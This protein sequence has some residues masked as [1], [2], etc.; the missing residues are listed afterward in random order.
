MYK[1]IVASDLH[2]DSHPKRTP[3]RDFRL[4]QSFIV[5]DNII[6]LAK[7]EGATNFLFL[8]GDIVDKHDHDSTTHHVV[9]ECLQRLADSFD[10]VYFILGNH[11]ILNRSVSAESREGDLKFSYI[12]LY[13]P[14]KFIYADRTVL[15][16]EGVRI[17]FR[18]HTSAAELDLSFLDGNP[19]DILVTHISRAYSEKC[20]YEVQRYSDALVRGNL[21]SGHIHQSKCLGKDVSIGVGQKCSISDD[22]PQALVLELNQGSYRFKHEALDPERKQMD[23]I[24]DLTIS[25]DFYDEATNTYHVAKKDEEK[26][27]ELVA[28]SLRGGTALETLNK[29]VGAKVRCLKRLRQQ[30]T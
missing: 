8:A 22:I 17:G 20:D 23:I 13:K 24:P 29:Y 27:A 7:R 19:V 1:G 21:I 4:K 14:E 9:K 3:T 5:V 6:N 28:S 2:L 10:E 12:T 30:Q 18:N 25:T 15:E 11:D 26:I 16:R